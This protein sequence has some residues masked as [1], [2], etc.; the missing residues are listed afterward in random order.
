M[1]NKN[2]YLSTGQSL[3]AG[4]V[5][6]QRHLSGWIRFTR[7]HIDLKDLIREWWR[8]AL[9]NIFTGTLLGSS[10]KKSLLL[11]LYPPWCP[12]ALPAFKSATLADRK[13]DSYEALNMP[14]VFPESGLPVIHTPE[15][16]SDSFDVKLG[17]VT[18]KTAYID[19][20]AETGKE[21]YE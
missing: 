17:T 16:W 14:H 13:P 1:T 5:L 11:L 7:L 12:L 6:L 20:Q 10:T 2:C 18:N 3:L 8:A 15:R 19:Y 4:W 21:Y 9:G